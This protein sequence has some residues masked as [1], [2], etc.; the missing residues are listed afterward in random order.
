MSTTTT[1]RRP[2]DYVRAEPGEFADTPAMLR[3]AKSVARLAA[4]MAMQ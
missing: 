4:V 1:W 2:A 3:R